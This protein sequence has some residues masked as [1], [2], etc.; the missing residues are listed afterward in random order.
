MV[1]SNRMEAIIWMSDYEMI[2]ADDLVP[3]SAESLGFYKSVENASIHDE[4]IWM[5]L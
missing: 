1:P 2:E 4:A 3:D 5:N